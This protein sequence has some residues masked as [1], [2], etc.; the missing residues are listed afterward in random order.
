MSTNVHMLGTAN[1][2][3]PGRSFGTFLWGRF[4]VVISWRPGPWRIACLI[5]DRQFTFGLNNSNTSSAPSGSFP[6]LLAK[7]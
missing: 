3:C 5:I 2:A 1:L 4:H 7:S 6:A